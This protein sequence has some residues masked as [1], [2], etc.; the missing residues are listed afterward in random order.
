MFKECKI[1]MLPADEKSIT[2]PAFAKNHIVKCIKEWRPIGNEKIPEGKLSWCVNHSEG[3]LKYYQAQH[4][5][6]L[7]D[8]EIKEG[9]WYYDYMYRLVLR[10]TSISTHKGDNDYKKI[11]AT[12]NTSLIDTIHKPAKE[13][14][15]IWELPQPSQSFIEKYIDEYNKGNIITN[16]MVEYENKMYCKH[17]A[18]V[19]VYNN[20]NWKCIRC[21]DINYDVVDKLKINPKDNT[22]TI[23]KVKD[24]WSKEEVSNLMMQAWI[25]GQANPNCHYTFREEWIEKNILNI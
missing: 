9:D 6:T 21:N 16:V 14:Q 25:F 11:I 24:S 13:F 23:R 12:T 17:C 20:R 7:S 18:D 19:L 15:Y 5:Y 1:I 4:L 10:A 3:V 2:S 8:D 22:I